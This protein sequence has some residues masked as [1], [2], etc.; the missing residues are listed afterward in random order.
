V[1]FGE[2][3]EDGALA[4]L[5]LQRPLV[6]LDRGLVVAEVGARHAVH[7]GFLSLNRT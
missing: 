2:G 3:G 5:K 7:E 1:G 6:Q 4:G